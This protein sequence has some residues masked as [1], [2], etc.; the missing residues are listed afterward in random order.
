MAREESKLKTIKK[1]FT[2]LAFL[3]VAS[4]LVSIFSDLPL[5]SLLLGQRE[6]KP[7]NQP[8]NLLF[9]LGGA[10]IHK[11]QGFMS[12]RL[13]Y[14][15]MLI[16]VL[17][18]LMGEAL[19][20]FLKKEKLPIAAYALCFLLG[21]CV[22]WLTGVRSAL[23]G[24][25]GSLPILFWSLRPKLNS[26]FL[27]KITK[28]KKKILGYTLAG[29]CL[30]VVVFAVL[31]VRFKLHSQLIRPV[32]RTSDFGRAFMWSESGEMIKKDPFL[33]VGSKNYSHV[34]ARWRKEFLQANPDSWYFM[35]FIP[36]RHVH[37]DILDL[38]YKHGFLAVF[39]FLAMLFL[40]L[41]YMF[42]P[43]LGRGLEKR[44]IFLLCGCTA[45]FLAGF[46]QCYLMDD[47]VGLVFWLSLAIGLRTDSKALLP[48]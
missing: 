43:A 20:N 12:T 6:Y 42:Y 24:F 18:Y 30:L 28:Q 23:L 35:Y 46:A 8:Q 33:G 31:A 25:I 44:N 39:F 15:G 38:W 32:L 48:S 3:L 37:S 1:G 47:E 11:P 29:A 27:Q 40:I 16:L 13:T 10:A 45:F 19:Q 2:A 7:S 4:G 17:P 5:S 14:A 36:T 21:L 22:L 34:S 41:K 26:V 9:T